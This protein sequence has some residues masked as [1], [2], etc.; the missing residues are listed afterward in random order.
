MSAFGEYNPPSFYNFRPFFTIQPVQATRE[1]QLNLWKE[2]IVGY[3]VFHKTFRMV[4]PPSFPLFKNNTIGRQLSPSAIKTVIEHII[5]EGVAQWE[6]PSNP[7]NLL[8]MSKSTATIAHELY[9]WANKQNLL[10]FVVTVYELHSGDEYTDSPVM[11]MDL[12][13]LRKALEVLET[14]GKAIFIAG[15]NVD[16]DGVKFMA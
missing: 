15:A 12:V 13:V 10:G 3:H 8:V 5:H 1:K 7:V 6:D 11:G 9:T 4:D 14:S 2:L 16:E